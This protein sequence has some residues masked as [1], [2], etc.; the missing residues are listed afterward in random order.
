MATLNRPPLTNR[1]HQFPSTV[2]PIKSQRT[3]SGSKRPRSP[4]PS[5][6]PSAFHPTSKRVKA[7]M[8]PS[9][10]PKARDRLR[11]RKHVEREQQKAEFKEKYTRAFPS[12]TFYFDELN[13]GSVALDTYEEMI[14]ELGGKIVKFLDRAVTHFISNRPDA[15][16]VVSAD[17]ENHPKP[18][19][20]LKSPIKLKGRV[21]ENSDHNNS[22]ASSTTL[23]YKVWNTTKLESVLTRLLDPPTASTSTAPSTVKKQVPS[24]AR[25]LKSEQIHGTTERD[26]TQK[27]Y[28]YKYFARGSKFVLIED[29]RHELATIAAHEYPVPKTREGAL[30]KPPWPVLYCHPQARGPFIAFDEK[31]KRRWEKVQRA[32]GEQKAERKEYSN[33]IRQ[34]EFMK[35]KAEANM[36]AKRSGD[37]R[38]SVSMNNL[39][40]AARNDECFLDLDGDGDNLDS[41]V[42]SGFLASGAAGYMAASGNSV[43]ITSTI[44]TTST[45]GYTSRAFQLPSS[46]SART[47]YVTTSRRLTSTAA[48]KENKAPLMGPPAVIPERQPLLRKSRSTNTLKLPKREEGSKPG[49]CESCRIKFDD[50]KAHI[51]GRKHQRFATNDANFLQLDCVLARVQRR[52]KADVLDARLKREETRRYHCR[53]GRHGSGSS[54]DNPESP[55]LM[56][57]TFQYGVHEDFDMQGDSD[58]ISDCD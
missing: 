1:S 36:H 29:L 56:G 12:F 10:A 54:S 14:E 20:G 22:V 7:A 45:A 3:A 55:L 37:L 46:V 40:R 11:E 23:I 38:R 6:D 28:D 4:E 33:K 27:R 32:E 15:T 5:A 2:S 47:K 17:K 53:G 57:R 42:A 30:A 18:G 16:L 41:A 51:V 26:P 48:D 34:A 39:H 8:D 44:G 24:L 52:T 49:Y 58:R 25:L 35:R 50:F 19:V 43:S 31:E 13:L 9:P 21:I